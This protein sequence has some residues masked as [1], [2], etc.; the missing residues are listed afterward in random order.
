VQYKR[1]PVRFLSPPTKMDNHVEVWG[2][3]ETGEVFTDYE[4]YLQRIKLECLSL[5]QVQ[6]KFTCDIT[7][8]S[9]LTYFEALNSE[10]H[11]SRDVESNFPEP[12][13]EPVLRRV[14]FSQTARL[15]DL[16]NEVHEHF[17]E[18]FFPGEQIIATNEQNDRLEGTI[19][20]KVSFP[21]YIDKG[22]QVRAAISNYFVQLSTGTGNDSEAFFDNHHLTR[23][24]KVF[25]KL[26]LKSFLK[27]SITRE[28]HHN[29][30]WMVKEHIAQE[31]RISTELPP[32]LQPQVIAESRR[33]MAGKM[34]HA[35]EMGP[36]GHHPGA[37]DPHFIPYQQGVTPPPGVQYLTPSLHPL[38]P[39]GADF[40]QFQP[41]A[42]PVPTTM[43]QKPPPP[44]PVKYP[45]DDLE[46][47]P[48]NNGVQRPTLKFIGR[49][50]KKGEPNGTNEETDEETDYSEIR[51]ESV[52]LLL[53]I[54]NTLNVHETVFVLDSFTFDDLLEAMRFSSDEVECQLFNEI[55]CAVLKQ[56]VNTD[57][58]LLVD[59]PEI[60][61]EDSDEEEEEESAEATPEPEPPKRTTR[62]S[63]RKA[64][65]EALQKDRSP[66]VDPN[67]PAHRAA[68]MLS[69]FEWID[70]LK[71]R[72]FR[73]G[74]WQTIMVGILHQLSL[75]ERHKEECEDILKQLAPT[76]MSPTRETAKTCYTWM[77]VNSKIKA[78]QIICMLSVTT[79][80]IREYLENCSEAMT[81]LRKQKIEY[82]RMRKP[83]VE[84]LRE[85]DDQRKALI[86]EEQP[87]PPVANGTEAHDTSMADTTAELIASSPESDDPEDEEEVSTRALRR[88]QERKRKRDENSARREKEKKEKADAKNPKMSAKMKKIIRDIEKKKEKIKECE[89]KIAEYDNDLREANC[90]RT[91][92]LGKDRFSNRYWWFEKNGMP[93]SGMP[94]SST[95]HY[96]YANGRIWVQGPDDMEREG[97]L[98]LNDD[99]MAGYK[100]AFGFTIQERRDAEEGPTQ[101]QTAREWGYLDDPEVVDQLIG[102][103]DERGKR[104]KDLRKEMQIWKDTIMTYMS[105]LREH[106]DEVETK[107]A[108]GEEQATRVSTRTKTYVDVDA[109]KWQC[110]AW[111]NEKALAELG[112]LHS[113]QPRPRK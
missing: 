18:D 100:N 11:G 57:G 34:K 76:D 50:V 54:W 36:N 86:L 15:D 80:A 61:E 99:E 64:E 40:S 70:H 6:R 87:P 60:E 35:V 77:D 78:L 31:Y 39:Y 26:L 17:K 20:E 105:R 79:R 65:A 75:D 94:D 44:P 38:M 13:R 107:K 83:L 37:H 30:V 58:K 63:L 9:G 111:R 27:H 67:K 4:S 45:I 113:E 72:D 55:H 16:V 90:Q 19:R 22:V 112:H 109:S 10:L 91:K 41:W 51:M 92:L 84:E 98:E 43:P 48:K 53:E 106:L 42:G 82:Q 97:F 46:V 47:P 2:I 71:D 93:F 88:G 7:G 101:L 5:T 108:E 33:L 14:Q 69:D 56:L 96:G 12:L 104:E 1:K 102:W 3:D 32:H 24:R 8:H 68:E 29:A 66:S 95:A 73:S 59:L 25:S 103:L 85:L 21:A 28:P 89:D 74:G 23:D 81:E 52:G 110:L 49:Q 62:G